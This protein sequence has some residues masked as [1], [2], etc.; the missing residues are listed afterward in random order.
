MISHLPHVRDVG[1]WNYRLL[2]SV[3]PCLCGEY[4][5]ARGDKYSRLTPQVPSL[6]PRYSLLVTG[7]YFHVRVDWF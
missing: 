4:I 5:C 3:P 6:Y 7:Y 1:F 2:R